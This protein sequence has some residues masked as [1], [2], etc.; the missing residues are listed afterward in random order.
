MTVVAK[1]PERVRGK[2]VLIVAIEDDGCATGNA[3][4]A[5]KNFEIVFADNVTPGLMLELGLPIPCDGSRNMSA[6]ERVGVFVDLDDPEISVLE[7]FLDP[8]RRDE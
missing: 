3:R 7:V 1:E 8:G 4:F 5:E 2:P 6:I